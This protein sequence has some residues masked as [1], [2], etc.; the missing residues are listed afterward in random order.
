MIDFVRSGEELQ[1]ICRLLVGILF[2]QGCILYANANQGR[3]H[4]NSFLCLLLVVAM[5]WGG[6]EGATWILRRS[7][8]CSQSKNIGDWQF[9]WLQLGIP[10]AVWGISGL[11]TCWLLSKCIK[12]ALIGLGAEQFYLGCLIWLVLFPFLGG[13][14]V[15]REAIP[16]VKRLLWGGLVG[17][18]LCLGMYLWVYPAPFEFFS[19]LNVIKLTTAIEKDYYFLFMYVLGASTL[20]GVICSCGLFTAQDPEADKR[21]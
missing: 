7:P 4:L 21:D 6:V 9:L 5:C 20:W 1:R 3:V 11:G 13:P 8:F 10:G 17:Q 12:S 19:L 18:L 15:L 2:L 16:L 14:L